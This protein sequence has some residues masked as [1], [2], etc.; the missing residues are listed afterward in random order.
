MTEASS[1]ESQ[2]IE[3]DGVRLEFIRIPAA[4]LGLPPLVFLH[5]GLGSV[6][7]WRDFPAKVAEATG[8]EVIV[9]SR[10]GYGQSDK[11]AA[12][13]TVDYMHD[14]ARQVLP[15]LLKQLGLERPVLIGHSDGGS[16]ALIFAGSK[17]APLSGLILMAPHVFVE[18]ITVASIAAAK[19]A[20]ETTD[21]GKRL[22]R[23]HADADHSF[24]GWNDIWLLPAFR[25][26]NV[27]EFVPR[28]EC[29]I[30]VI[31]GRDDEYGTP[32]QVDSIERLARAPCEIALLADCR[33]SPHRD[34]PARTLE[35]IAGFV[36]RVATSAG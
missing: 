26:W 27:E 25:D 3:I 11:L 20:Y 30:L 17:I 12:A 35:L 13:N 7:M 31:Q 5:E 22:G 21:L 2:F 29:P 23:Y 1:S 6:A 8:A 36:A 16:I 24:W 19:V 15:R 28:V 10:R 18:D 4:K 32:A 33:H 34:Q 14:E 9:Y